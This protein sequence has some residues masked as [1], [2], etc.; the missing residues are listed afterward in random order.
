[1][2]VGAIAAWTGP[3]CDLAQPSC[4]FGENDTLTTP[5]ELLV[6]ADGAQRAR[7]LRGGRRNEG[8]LE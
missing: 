6:I 7:V 2:G 5:A 1:V 8:S 4:P 3:R